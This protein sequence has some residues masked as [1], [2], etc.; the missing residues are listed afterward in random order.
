MLADG[1]M[2][3]I[4]MATIIWRS[5][6]KVRATDGGTG[7]NSKMIRRRRSDASRLHF[8][9]MILPMF[10]YPGMKSLARQRNHAVAGK[11]QPGCDTSNHGNKY[12]KRQSGKWSAATEFEKTEA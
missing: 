8:I 2:V 7:L 3:A 12:V 4:V 6:L 5:R 1:A 9:T 10:M 11:H